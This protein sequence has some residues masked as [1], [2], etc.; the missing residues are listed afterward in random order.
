MSD[1]NVQEKAQ[2]IISQGITMEADAAW[3]EN[4][5]KKEGHVRG[6][7][8]ISDE[9]EEIGGTNTAPPPLAYFT[10]ALGF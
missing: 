8:L 5:M 4:P 2:R 1:I 6:F 9:P 3:M 10:V 7:T